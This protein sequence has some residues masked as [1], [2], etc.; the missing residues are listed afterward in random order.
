VYIAPDPSNPSQQITW[1][2]GELNVSDP[3]AGTFGGQASTLS[4]AEQN[5][6]QGV[7]GSF[8]A[9]GNSLSS[10]L[11]PNYAPAPPNAASATID[12]TAQIQQILAAYQ[13]AAQQS[14]MN[15]N[16]SLAAAGITGG[17]TVGAQDQLQGQ[18]AASLAPTLGSAIGDANTSNQ[19]AENNT[20]QYNISNAINAENGNVSTANNFEQFLASL[21][22][23]DWSQLLGSYT[24]LQQSGL[25]GQ[26]GI[27]QA[28]TQNYAN[29]QGT[30][31]GISSLGSALG[32]YY[33]QSTPSSTSN[34][35]STQDPVYGVG[36]SGGEYS[37][38]GG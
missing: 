36:G 30:A 9:N 12:P 35:T 37:G 13:P 31:A 16:N 20:N 7:G 29:P 10:A 6:A 25:S 28:S 11:Q 19:S 22:N 8:A 24:G 33:G 15:L 23:S 26:Q 34:T 32:N 38:Y 3:T 14:T 18:L 17:G 5:E 21:Q 2:N 27:N 1:S 4:Q